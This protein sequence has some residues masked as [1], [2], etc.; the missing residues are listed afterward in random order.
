MRFFL[1]A[2]LSGLAALAVVNALPA[3]NGRLFADCCE[4]DVI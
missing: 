3:E 4:Y 2:V 1:F